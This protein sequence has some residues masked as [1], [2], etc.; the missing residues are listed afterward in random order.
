MDSVSL[1]NTISKLEE[2]E[3]MS[4]SFACF[5]DAEDRQ[6]D[7]ITTECLEINNTILDTY[8]ILSDAISG[9]CIP[10]SS[11]AIMSVRSAGCRL[12]SPNGWTEGA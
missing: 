1:T 7:A 4:L 6:K 3:A 12:S 9:A 11:A 8:T 5:K 10:I 2:Q